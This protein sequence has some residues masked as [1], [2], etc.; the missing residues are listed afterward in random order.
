VRNNIRLKLE[1]MS[2]ALHD[3]DSDGV[4]E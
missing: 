4:H 3:N 1:K 2:K